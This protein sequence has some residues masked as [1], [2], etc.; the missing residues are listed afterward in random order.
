LLSAEV[1]DSRTSRDHHSH[2]A[3]T[4]SALA[5]SNHPINICSQQSPIRDKISNPQFVISNSELSSYREY[6]AF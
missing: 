4:Q 6:D 3:I 2:S 1:R 5:I